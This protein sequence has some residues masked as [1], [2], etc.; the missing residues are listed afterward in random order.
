MSTRPRTAFTM[1]LKTRRC[2]SCGGKINNQL[3]RCK[4]CGS[5]QPKPKKNKK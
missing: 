3:I 5:A 1:I 4:K 2:S